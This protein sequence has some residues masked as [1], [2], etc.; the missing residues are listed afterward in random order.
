MVEDEV[1]KNF[2]LQHNVESN[3]SLHRGSKSSELYQNSSTLLKS[4]LDSGV[5]KVILCCGTNDIANLPFTSHT[6]KEIAQHIA[7]VVCKFNIL[8]TDK[9]ATLLYVTPTP[10]SY[11]SATGFTEFSEALN[12]LLTSNKI[13]F[14]EPFQILKT[15]TDMSYDDVI[16]HSASDYLH[17]KFEAGRQILKASLSHFGIGCVLNTSTIQNPLY[18]APQKH[19]TNVC[20][21]YS[22]NGH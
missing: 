9:N 6:L 10:N 1:S 8:C 2:I 3:I 20:F 11:V 13:Q 22:S 7:D 5:N 12:S 21:K 18:T 17:R 16:R 4:Y 15:S 14:I 19:H